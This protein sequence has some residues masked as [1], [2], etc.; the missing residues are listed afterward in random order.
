M[1]RNFKELSACNCLELSDSALSKL[2]QLYAFHGLAGAG[3]EEPL[4]KTKAAAPIPAAA[5]PPS[6]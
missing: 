5:A 2:R 3:D 6:R 1:F 4:D